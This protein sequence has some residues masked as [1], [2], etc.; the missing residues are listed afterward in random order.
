[1]EKLWTR[2]RAL[3]ADDIARQVEVAFEM[4]LLATADRD[5]LAGRKPVYIGSAQGQFEVGAEPALL[6]RFRRESVEEHANQGRT[7]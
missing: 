6:T 7:D 1:M 4:P 2:A 3:F 5:D